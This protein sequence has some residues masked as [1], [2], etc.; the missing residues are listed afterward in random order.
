M[1]SA[2]KVVSL[3]AIMAAVVMCQIS[4]ASGWTG[5][6]QLVRPSTTHLLFSAPPIRYPHTAVRRSN[7]DVTRMYRRNA[8][9][10]DRNFGS[11]TTRMKLSSRNA[12]SSAASDT[13]V[14]WP[15]SS[16]TSSAANR[17]TTTSAIVDETGM[18]SDDEEIFDDEECFE[19]SIDD[20]SNITATFPKGVVE[21]FFIASLSA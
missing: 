17:Y 16:S 13:G 5:R 15:T 3:M 8:F 11:T 12:A 14:Q 7:M 20:D 1:L 9:N 19:S 6:R 2:D 4:M 21:D 10:N 18:D